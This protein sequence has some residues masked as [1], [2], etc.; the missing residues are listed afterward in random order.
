MLE[1][2]RRRDDYGTLIFRG[3]V[4]VKTVDL[5]E[6]PRQWRAAIRQRARADR[7]K[8]RTGENEQEGFV[9]AMLAGGDTEMRAIESERHVRL[10][11]D[12]LVPRAVAMHHEPT[13]ALR[14][15]D[16]TLL[17][18]QRCEA[19]GYAQTSKPSLIGGALFDEECPHDD[20]PKGTDLTV[21]TGWG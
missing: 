15:G 10:L 14:D 3:H 11:F 20:P 16:E 5:D 4:T 6:R 18:C 9:W 13:L 8:V 17:V 12:A 21:M 7:I 19:P 1:R 2:V